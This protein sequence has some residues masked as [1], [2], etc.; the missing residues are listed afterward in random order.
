MNTFVMKSHF[1]R[2]LRVRSAKLGQKCFFFLLEMGWELICLKKI[3]R[4]D[5]ERQ[6]IAPLGCHH[7]SSDVLYGPMECHGGG[8]IGECAL[9]AVLCE[10][11][12][13]DSFHVE[14]YWNTVKI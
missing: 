13:C 14:L 7:R 5:G 11:E 4:W 2:K 1:F 9:L 6:L 10:R 3:S 12:T 8:F